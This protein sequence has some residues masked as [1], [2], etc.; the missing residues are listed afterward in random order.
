MIRCTTS[1]GQLDGIDFM[2]L[3]SIKR[4]IGQEIW[5]RNKQEIKNFEMSNIWIIDESSIGFRQFLGKLVLKTSKRVS[6]VLDFKRKLQCLGEKTV[7]TVGAMACVQD[8]DRI[9]MKD[10]WSLCL[11]NLWTL[12][13]V[14]EPGVVALRV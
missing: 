7:G 14:N 9:K 5:R 11:A 10:F 1:I 6:S 8:L 12:S 4:I 13:I 2:D 3:K